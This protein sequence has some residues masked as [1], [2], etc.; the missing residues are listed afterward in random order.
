MKYFLFLIGLAV[1]L[2]G[3]CCS[4]SEPKFMEKYIQSDFVARVTITETF[5]NQGSALHYQSSIVIHQ[6]FKGNLAN[7]ISIMGSSDGKRR[8][9]CDIFFEK[10]TEM[11]VYAQKSD[12]GRY[13]FDSCSGYVVLSKLRRGD[14]KRELEMLNFLQQRGIVT[15]NRTWYGVALAEKLKAFQGEM[16]TR[17][18]AIF[19][20]TFTSNL[21]VD[22]VSTITGFYPD[23]DNKL[24]AILKESRWVSD[25]FGNDTSRNQVPAGSKL[26]FAFYYYPAEGKYP[27]FISEHD[28]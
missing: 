19:E 12:D 11:L 8:T 25:R 10:G 14:E 27:S 18:F 21:Q 6:L 22:S 4:C 2:K 5:P 16:L 20:I 9:S 28:L 15:T 7:A 26:L 3:T 17:S 1:S 23:L 24:I 13:I